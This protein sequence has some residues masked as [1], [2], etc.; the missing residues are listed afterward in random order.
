MSSLCLHDMFVT[1]P[2]KERKTK[3]WNVVDNHCFQDQDIKVLILALPPTSRVTLSK[4]L[5]PSIKLSTE[6]TAA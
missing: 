5:K 2:Y 6:P 3:G 4:S 1:L